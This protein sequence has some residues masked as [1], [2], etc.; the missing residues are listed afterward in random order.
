MAKSESFSAPIERARSGGAFVRVPFD[1]EAVFGM[2]RVP[3]VATID[4][5]E[6]RGSLV[7]MGAECHVLGVL[8]DIQAQIGKSVG[9]VVSVTVTQDDA[10]R[11]VTVPDDLAAAFADNA[12]AQRHFD[13]MS[14]SAKREYVLWIESAKKAETRMSR[15]TKAI[16]QLAEGKRLR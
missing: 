16:E 13:S 15:V 9:D 8:K 11:E 3:I 10:P 1:V 5:V 7:R 6:Y 12:G 4:G 14:Y 2:K